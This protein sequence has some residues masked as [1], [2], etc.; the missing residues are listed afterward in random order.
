MLDVT[1]ACGGSW[2]VCVSDSSERC[3]TGDGVG[4]RSRAPGLG[5]LASMML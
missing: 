5:M 1:V 3:E 4:W 2:C